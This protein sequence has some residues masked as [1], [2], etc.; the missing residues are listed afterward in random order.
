MVVFS[1]SPYEV[2]VKELHSRVEEEAKK[3]QNVLEAKDNA[4]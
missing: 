2:K 3:L 4:L 1:L